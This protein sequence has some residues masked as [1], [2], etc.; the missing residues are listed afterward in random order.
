MKLLRARWLCIA[1]LAA[2]TLA[3]AKDPLT[4]AA[5]VAAMGRG[6]NIV[7]YDPLW[8]D[9]SKARFQQKLVPILQELG[10][11]KGL[12]MLFSAADSG[13]VWADPGLDLID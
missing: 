10:R 13:L 7:G 11:E 4:P 6:V 1:A 12:Q 8:Q 2:A 3:Q 5:Q 9:A